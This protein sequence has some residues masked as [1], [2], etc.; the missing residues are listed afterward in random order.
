M[1]VCSDGKEERH[2]GKNWWRRIPSRGNKGPGAPDKE[3]LTAEGLLGA[4]GY[5][6]EMTQE[7]EAVASS[8]WFR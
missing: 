4:V 7:G 3:E 1:C 8:S 6:V 5:Q 2:H